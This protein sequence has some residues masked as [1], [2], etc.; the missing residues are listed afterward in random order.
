MRLLDDVRLIE[1]EIL[2]PPTVGTSASKRP[3]GAPNV[4]K[5]RARR[6][7]LYPVILRHRSHNITRLLLRRR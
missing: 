3:Y 5:I 1:S 6:Y 7:G 2:A 4:T